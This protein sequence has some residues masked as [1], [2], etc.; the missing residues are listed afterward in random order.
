MA[1]K[2]MYIPND[3]TQNYYFFRLQLVVELKRFDTQLNNATTQ[4]SIKDP[5]VVKPTNKKMAL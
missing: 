3:A 5:K 2:L 4:S 1:N